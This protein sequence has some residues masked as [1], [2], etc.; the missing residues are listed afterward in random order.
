MQ[1]IILNG[2]L[3]G[4]SYVDAVG[5]G[6]HLA[7]TDGG[8]QAT[9]HTL[10]DEKVAYCLGCFECWT[11][12]PGV[13]RIDDDGRRLAAALIASDLAVYLTPVT[14]GG[15]SSELKKYVDRSIPLVSPF[16]TRIYGEVHH[17]A[18]YARYPSLVAVGV[19]PEPDPAQE[20]IFAALIERNAINL[21]APF[22]SSL[23]VYR[24]QQPDA[25]AAS[26]GGMLRSCME[27]PA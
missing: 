11:K 14:F 6:L 24:G 9:Y 7:L 5:A 26:L 4:D 23:V 12:T 1:A 10:R 27:V 20:R 18:R 3:P 25:A 17:H 2:A 19:L 13:C 21:H 16:F 22:H 15:Y 8:W